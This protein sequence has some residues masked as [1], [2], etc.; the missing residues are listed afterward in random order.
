MGYKTKREIADAEQIIINSNIESFY[1]L[2]K[3]NQNDL[4][5]S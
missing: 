2:D 3:N 1:H 4:K 5:D